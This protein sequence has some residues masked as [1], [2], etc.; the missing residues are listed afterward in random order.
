MS[1]K[2]IKDPYTS[3]IYHKEKI[4]LAFSYAPRI[5]PCNRCGHPVADGYICITCGN[6]NPI[7]EE[8]E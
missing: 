6:E 3:R 8:I 5:Y 1:Y 4:E 2:P 7:D